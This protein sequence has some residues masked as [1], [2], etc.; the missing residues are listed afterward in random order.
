MS[1][2]VVTNLG[3]RQVFVMA[4][5]GLVQAL[6]LPVVIFDSLNR[7][8]RIQFSNSTYELCLPIQGLNS[9]WGGCNVRQ[10]I[11][12]ELVITTIFLCHTQ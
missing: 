6:S 11:S 7:S 5:K 4:P 3:S 10:P 1:S 9:F 8:L 2:W 12:S